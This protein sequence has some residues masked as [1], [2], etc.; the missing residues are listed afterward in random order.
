MD[1]FIP[2]PAFESNA[3][4]VDTFLFRIMN[5]V[6][7]M[8]GRIFGPA[9]R[10]LLLNSHDPVQQID[11]M[12]RRPADAN[13]LVGILGIEHSIKVLEIE[14]YGI[15][16]YDIQRQSMRLT[17]RVHA[18]EIENRSERHVNPRLLEPCFDIDHVFWDATG[19]FEVRRSYERLGRQVVGGP[20]PVACPI[21]VAMHAVMHRRFC[22]VNRLV[23]RSASAMAGMLKLAQKLVLSGYIHD[24]TT[25][26]YLRCPIV[27]LALPDDLPCTILGDEAL[28]TPEPQDL[29]P[30]V[31]SLPCNHVFSIKGICRLLHSTPPIM[32]CPSCGD[33]FCPEVAVV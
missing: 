1:G 21:G 33:K 31:V 24:Q 6:S 32:R 16:R 9:V 8:G 12:F 2:V 11:C 29:Q 20:V 26:A 10:R 30:C 18:Y 28:S 27:L 13:R 23:V 17:L 7:G 14:P 5:Y 3:E 19:I 25:H 22:V 4:A 15:Y